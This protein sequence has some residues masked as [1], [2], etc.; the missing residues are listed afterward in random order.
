MMKME[1]TAPRS[2]RRRRR[3]RIAAV[4]FV[5]LLALVLFGRDLPRLVAE[6]VLSAVLDARVELGAIELVSRERLILRR[7]QI[8]RLQA[9]PTIE[10]VEIDEVSLGGRFEELRRRRLR[11][12]AFGEVTV[13]VDASSPFELPAAGGGRGVAIDR[14]A[15]RELELNLHREGSASTLRG[16]AELFDIG[17]GPHGRVALRSERVDL[18][19]ARGLFSA[20]AGWPVSGEA[21]DA[22]GEWRLSAGGTEFSAATGALEVAFP[23]G[24]AALPRFEIRGERVGART[25]VEAVMPR[26]DLELEP[27][28][29]S[30]NASP[31]ASRLALLD[32]EL[33]LTVEETGQHGLF[34]SADLEATNLSRAELEVRRH[35]EAPQW[36]DLKLE[37]ADADLALV[38]GPWPLAGRFDLELTGSEPRFDYRLDARLA[39]WPDA[40]APTLEGR[41]RARFQGSGE[42]RLDPPGGTF[43][44]TV[45]L[46]A[47][48]QGRI[49]GGTWPPQLF[50][51][52]LLAEGRFPWPLR[53]ARGKARFEPRRGGA[54]VLH[55]ALDRGAEA[56][57]EGLWRWSGASFDTLF[58]LLEPFGLSRPTVLTSG[59]VGGSGE[60]FGRLRDP[61]LTANLDLEAVDLVPDAESPEESPPWRV[62]GWSGRV[63]LERRPD[64]APWR[65]RVPKS[66]GSWIWRQARPLPF[67]LKIARGTL[68]QD[69]SRTAFDGL[70]LELDAF[71]SIDGSGAWTFKP[72]SKLEADLQLA[73]ASLSDWNRHLELVELEPGSSIDGSISGGGELIYE[74]D[75]G[76]R[77]DGTAG[78]DGADYAS[79]DGAR[80]IDGFGGR[81]QL[82]LEQQQ[83]E[84]VTFVARGHTGGFQLLWDTIY[85][86]Y[87]SL[88]S[89]LDLSGQI[90]PLAITARGTLPEGPRFGVSL[91]APDGLEQS[92]ALGVELEIDDLARTQERYL[93]PLIAEELEGVELSG[94]LALDVQ[95]S[96]DQRGLRALDGGL[97]I[98]DLDVVTPLPLRLESVHLELPFELRRS[99]E[100]SSADRFEGPLLVG[101]LRAGG[102]K[103]RQLQLPPIDT[104]LVIIA[105]TVELE[106]P[107]ELPTL[108]GRVTLE[109]LAAENL[110]GDERVLTTSLRWSDLRLDLLSERLSFLPLEGTLEGHLPRVAVT[111][112]GRLEVTGVGEARLFGGRI[113]LREIAARDLFSAYPKFRFSADFEELDLARLTRRFD[114]GE[115]SGLL[116]GTIDGAE[117][118]REVP[119]AFTARFAT[120]KRKGVE[121]R[122]DIK[123]I[124]NLTLIGNG[125][126]A[127][128]FDRGLLQFFDSYRYAG[129]GVEAR[130]DD[131]TM[132]I[133]GLEKRGDK[134][135]FLRGRLPLRI[136]IVNARPNVRV[137]FSSMVNRLRNLDFSGVKTER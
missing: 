117:F 103:L 95:L 132:I 20:T 12:L 93:R 29:G 112:D 84:P 55:G 3:L 101:R 54:L 131:D 116:S 18:A 64:G 6:R 118:F 44:V 88:E 69:L 15:V 49:A 125:E 83:D 62:E 50:P 52:R 76:W 102:L 74:P 51:A 137:S 134:E 27:A 9:L 80:V 1:T 67:T 75:R 36:R 70:G 123:A 89:E 21:F 8:E 34:L 105:D 4:L 96:R 119:T 106:Q 19:V 48:P 100:A 5:G 57:V 31:D 63:P 92:H 110:L 114:F 37:I 127:S 113:L 71:G 7:L 98:R 30:E 78:L 121:Q 130:L 43:D 13:E 46:P 68:E 107:L 109:S 17:T 85:G 94:A 60:I 86:D 91:N 10:R 135:L 39:R 87:S 35:A 40:L 23:G 72:A 22:S 56:T 133:R 128:V 81:W 42:V 59:R 2:T 33:Q 79:A 124:K 58:T 32:P 61:Q 129:F 45:D 115:M 73:R 104:P 41:T 99:G 25:T 111:A 53:S 108:G 14:V 16:S 66:A 11:E 82:E 122:L 65:W 77:L 47:P 28:S 38:P 24:S 90:E 136:D 120:V 26:L 97:E 126:T